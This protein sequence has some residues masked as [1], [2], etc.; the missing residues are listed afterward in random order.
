MLRSLPTACLFLTLAAPV[1]ADDTFF[2]RDGQ[3]VVF[4][5]DSNTFAG[6]WIGYLDAYLFTRFPERKYQLINLG[7]PSETVSGLSEPDH[8]YPRPD[9]HTRLEQALTKTKP[10]VVVVCYGM[11][12][13]IYYPFSEERLAKYRDGIQKLLDR[14]DRSGAKVVLMTPSPFDPTPLKAKLL[15]K[16]AEKFSWMRPYEEYDDVLTRY[17]EWLLTLREKGRLVV[18]AHAAVKRHLAEVRRDRPDYVLAG[19]GIHPSPTGHWLVAQEL[20]R[21][22]KAPADVDSVEIDAKE[23]KVVRG[24]VSDLAVEVAAVQFTWR[25]RLPLP[26]DP[27]WD[28]TLA[29]REKINDRL[30]RQRLTVTGLPGNRYDL[31]EG[32]TAFGGV[33]RADLESGVDLTHFEKLSTNTRGAEL[34]KLVEKR[35]QVLGLAWLTDV[36]HKRPDTPKGIPLADALRQ[37]AELET[38]IRKLAEPRKVTLRVVAPVKN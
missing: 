16:T 9:I 21:A 6:H 5:G 34:W 38:Q 28:K 24:P 35:Q 18:D 8:P 15:P 19:D 29:K 26:A 23:K 12:D 11:N 13:G 31:W 20:L 14:I 2:L 32:D 37:A 33:T 36:G 4:L 7:L 1:R 25:T 27:R 30:N 22:W 3:R 17:S 10:D